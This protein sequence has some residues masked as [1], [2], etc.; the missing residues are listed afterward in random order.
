MD[1]FVNDSSET[2]EE[3]DRPTSCKCRKHPTPKWKK[4]TIFRK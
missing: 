4:D 3:D 2:E 1:D